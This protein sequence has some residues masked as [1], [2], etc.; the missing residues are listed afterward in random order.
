MEN[1]QEQDLK[2]NFLK[3]FEDFFYFCFFSHFSKK[4]TFLSNLPVSIVYFR[5]F[6]STHAEK[7]IK[8]KLTLVVFLKT[9]V[10]TCKLHSNRLSL[11]SS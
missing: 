2:N 6:A 9:M 8:K 11:L 10:G 7:L 5:L 3:P 4:K 1:F